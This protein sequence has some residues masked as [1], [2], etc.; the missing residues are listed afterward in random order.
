MVAG[1]IFIGGT[2]MS[3]LGLGF[4]AAV[5]NE[6]NTLMALA[7]AVS[8]LL[9]LDLGWRLL[10]NKTVR[11]TGW[12]AAF[13]ALG[14]IMTFLG[15]VMTVTWPL[16]Q[17]A[18]NCCQQ[19]NII[20][21]E[22]I[23]AYGVILLTAAALFWRTMK[24]NRAGE[25][26]EG[27]DAALADRVGGDSY[28]AMLLET[29]QPLSVFVFAEGLALIALA[30]AGVRFKLFAAPPSEPISG[31]ASN[32][33]YIEAIFISTLYALMG[34]GAVLFAIF[35]RTAN[36]TIAKAIGVSWLIPG[37][38]WLFFASMNYYTHVGSLVK[39]SGRF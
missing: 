31:I 27:S 17:V 10:N 23:L 20:F 32:H 2:R 12:I 8:F 3:P 37:V 21:G 25:K 1:Q 6:Y 36:R 19:D 4:S 22:P 35:V 30:F 13:I 34:I 33:P 26:A 9:I 29:L 39:H 38:V 28:L 5:G 11:A 14:A 24:W 7:A 18:S 16:K 15:A